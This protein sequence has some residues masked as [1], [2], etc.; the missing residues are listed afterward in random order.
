MN[1]S[2]HRLRRGAYALVV[3]FLVACMS[4]VGS[5]SLSHAEDPP[6]SDVPTSHPY[7]T[8]IAWMNSEGIS[9]GWPDGTYRPS[10]PVDRDA[11]AAFF[12][13]YLGSPAYTAPTSSPF[14]DI[15]ASTQFY[16]E[17][18]W[19]KSSGISTGW[20]DGTYRPWT[21]TA[22][23]AMAA[24]MYRVA[25]SPSYT[26]PQVS[27]FYDVTPDIQFYKEMSWAYQS[28][29]ANNA[30]DGTFD[31]W[32]SVSREMMAVFMYRLA[33]PTDVAIQSVGLPGGAVGTPYSAA[34]RASGGTL[35][36]S[37]SA[38][39]LPAGL[40][41]SSEGVISGTPTTAGISTVQLTVIDAD[42]NSA[43]AS[44]SLSISADSGGVLAVATS[45]LPVGTAGS[46][47]PV[48][49]F[50]ATN[51]EAPYRWSASGL[52][53]G[54]TLSTDGKL[55]GTPIGAGQG[56]I[57]VQVTDNQGVRASAR[58]DLRVNSEL[59]ITTNSLSIGVA[60]SDYSF[61]VS[62]QGGVPPY[63]WSAAGLPAGL[64][65][66][67][68]GDVAGT[69]ASADWYE[70]AFTVTD[71]N[72]STASRTLELEIAAEND[73]DVLKC[74]AIT[75]DD[76]PLDYSRDLMDAFVEA[77]AQATFYDVGVNIQ[78]DP[79]ASREQYEAGMEVGLHGWQHIYYSNYGYDYVRYDL[80]A[81]AEMY[82][83]AVG[84]W[85]D[86]WRPPYGFYNPTVADAA[87][88]VGLATIMW[89]ENAFDYE[90][91]NAEALYED[92]VELAGRDAVLLMHDGV[93]SSSRS[94]GGLWQLTGATARAI[95]WIIED[96]QSQGYTLVTVST[97]LGEDPEPGEVYFDPDPIYH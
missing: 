26:A 35:P 19:M 87:G 66:D 6:F 33:H 61:R 84:P 48:T 13:R 55:S 74:I 7:Y 4:S 67:N 65:I 71:S 14:T 59:S 57:T 23:D 47:Y 82:E 39:D 30:D 38:T 44:M 22:R 32:E 89:T 37:W 76:G 12:Y 3:A 15:T 46:P 20:P 9:T 69:P 56:L 21:A 24:F 10:Q 36:F 96:L 42:N 11:M 77:G 68:N 60:G 51:G 40:T 85:P 92:T 41:I 90:Y 1:E 45:S 97:L 18:A 64:V 8:E 81:A 43:T 27:L 95:P 28:G 94:E 83:W 86:T 72:G 50:T 88:D 49:T 17:M 2:G 75:F 25:G 5:L 62:A 80:E 93:T 53:A 29:I 78:K 63:Q 52:P 73:C 54:L 79:D 16:K 91:T 70:V 58:L 34:L 31:P